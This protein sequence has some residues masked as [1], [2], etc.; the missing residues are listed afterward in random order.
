MGASYDFIITKNGEIQDFEQTIYQNG[1]FDKIVKDIILSVK[2]IP[3]YEGMNEDSI[4]VSIYLGY[5]RY[6][7]VKI[8]IGSTDFKHNERDIYMLLIDLKK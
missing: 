2:P 8:C 4:L 5:Q 6:N 7:E 3:F 1:Y